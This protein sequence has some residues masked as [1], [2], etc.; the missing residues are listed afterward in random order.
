MERPVTAAHRLSASGVHLAVHCAHP[1]RH[2]VEVPPDKPGPAAKKGT[3]V[4]SAIESYLTDGVYP[5]TEDPSFTLFSVWLDWWDRSPVSRFA[6]L[7]EVP[8]IL[9]VERRRV[10][11]L[12]R[13]SHRDYGDVEHTEIPMTLDLA[14][15]SPDR[16]IVF[17]WKTGK[18]GDA[19]AQLITNALAWS[20]H[21]K[22]GTARAQAIYLTE[23]G[24]IEGEVYQLDALDL[25]AHLVTLRRILRALPTAEPVAGEWCSAGYC[26]LRSKCGAHRAWLKANREPS[27]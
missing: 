6:H 20:I 1:F 14:A 2:D 9:D 22:R 23:T 4:H 27:L 7:S 5:G 10:R 16:A 25:D 11:Q 18:V 15:V 3:A 12:P 26:P 24:V 8:L 21:S 13:T 19:S 17:D